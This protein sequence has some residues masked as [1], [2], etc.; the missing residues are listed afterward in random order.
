MS[1]V[2]PSAKESNFIGA[3]ARHTESNQS[4]RIRLLNVYDDRE[5][6]DVQDIFD[7]V[8]C[9]MS[10][11]SMVFVMSVITVTF[12]MSMMYR[13]VQSN[14]PVYPVQSQESCPVNLLKLQLLKYI[15]LNYDRV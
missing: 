7:V 15:N 11:M 3:G 13:L 6:K 1:R 4:K 10:A 12:K 14:I 9:M 8:M 2:T 5:V